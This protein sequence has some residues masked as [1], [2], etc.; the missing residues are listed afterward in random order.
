[1]PR[2]QRL[3]YGTAKASKMPRDRSSRH[4]RLPPDN[5]IEAVST[6]NFKPRP[7]LILQIADVVV[8]IEREPARDD[9]GDGSGRGPGNPPGTHRR[10]SSPSLTVLEASKLERS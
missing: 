5:H 10:M 6:G 1:M 2:V 4:A 3:N 9:A 7:S 8:V